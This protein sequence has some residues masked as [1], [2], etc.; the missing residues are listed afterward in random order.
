MAKAPYFPP[1][2][3]IPPKTRLFQRMPPA[4]FVPIMGVFGLGLAW[5]RAVD[6]MGAPDAIG[7]LILGAVTLI[8]IFGLMA[9][10]MKLIQRPG[11]F[12]EDLGVLPGRAGLTTMAL[13]GYLLAAT[14]VPF[15]PMASG[16]ILF[17]SLLAHLTVLGWVVFAL[18]TGPRQARIVTPVWH[19]LFAGFILIPLAALPLGVQGLA[20]AGFWG[21]LAAAIAIWGASIAQFLKLRIPAPLRPL[22]AVHLAPASIGAMAAFMLGEVQIGYLLSSVALIILSA[23]LFFNRWLTEAGFSPF[24]GAFTFPLAAFCGLL[25]M[26]AG[27][28]GSEFLRVI[29]GLSLVIAT[30]VILPILYKILQMWAKGVL[31]VK[32]NAAQA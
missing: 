17:A 26:L 18:L 11:T 20:Q 8:Y 25:H 16:A 13:S 24:W 7:D 14:V 5:R 3:P 10:M 12:S 19:L 23:L 27:L 1:P 21:G 32:T 22:L 4:V 30:L 6:T 29:A 31:A 15:S 2:P 9:Y 28:V